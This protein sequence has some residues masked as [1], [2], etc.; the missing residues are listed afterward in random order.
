MQLFERMAQIREMETSVYSLAEGHIYHLSEGHLS[1][2][3]ERDALLAR[4]DA[5]VLRAQQMVEEAR[6]DISASTNP[7]ELYKQQLQF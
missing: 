1:E 5:E 4:K 2:I 6:S 7:S 3:R